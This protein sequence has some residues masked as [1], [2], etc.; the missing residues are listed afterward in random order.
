MLINSFLSVFIKKTSKS[1]LFANTHASR[2]ENFV[3]EIEYH[4]AGNSNRDLTKVKGELKLQRKA[5][6]RNK[7]CVT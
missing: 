4:T 6:S 1:K 3:A 5:I 7:N 2:E